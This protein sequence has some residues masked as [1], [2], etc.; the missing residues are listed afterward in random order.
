MKATPHRGLNS[1]RGVIRS[2]DLVDLSEEEIRDELSTQGVTAIKRIIIKRDGETIPTNTLILTFDRSAPPENIKAGYLSVRVSP[3]IPNPLR[4]FKCQKYGHGQNNCRNS[5]MCYRCGEKDHDGTT[6]QND[7][8]CVTCE[9]SHMASS[10]D[11]PKWK[12]RKR[13]S[14]D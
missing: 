14:K 12:K 1:S 6:C 8:K 5:N 13:N 10:K 9:G 2:R 7:L 4:C 11:C 3:Y